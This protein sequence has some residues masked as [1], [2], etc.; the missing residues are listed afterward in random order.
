[1]DKQVIY[2]ED[3]LN[4]E[5]SDAK[6][7]PK[8]IDENYKYKRSTLWNAISLVFQNVL[9]MPVKY[10]YAKC[11]LRIK[12]VGKEKF[13][14]CKK[15]GYFIYGNHTQIFADTFIPSLA[16]YPKRNF[17]IVNPENI[18]MKGSGWL[19]KLLGAVPVPGNIKATQNFI[20]YIE[21]LQNK[22]CSITIYP[23]AHIWPFYTKIRP[24]KSV[25]FKYPV[26]F[27]KPV[28][29]FVN[30]YQSYGKNNDKFRIV[31]YIDG[32][33]YPNQELPAKQAQEE[34]RNKVYDT[35]CER[36][37]NS[38]YEKIKYVKKEKE[39]F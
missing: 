4:D 10:F 22:K 19:I 11:A 16:N 34:L 12:Y 27:N 30:T 1:M 5:F 32:P 31:T 25:S 29:C 39:L 23:E 2:Y 8:K 3:E 13:K 6:I 26:K 7:I 15:T 17:F 14:E 18:S 36:S 21:L 35:M 9:S 38:N 33:F 24:F 37:K 20:D 28:Y